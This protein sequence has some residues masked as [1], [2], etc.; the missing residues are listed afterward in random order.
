MKVPSGAALLLTATL[1]FGSITPCAAGAD[2]APT[3]ITIAQ[4]A[5][6]TPC[7]SERSNA[8][9]REVADT[10]IDALNS[11][12]PTTTSSP[13]PSATP[14]SP[15]I[16]TPLRGPGALLATPPPTPIPSV[17]A[18]PLPTPTP[19]VTATAG[20]IF[21]SRQG[22]TTTAQPAPTL[23]PNAIAILADEV[24]GSEHLDQPG[25]AVGHVHIISNDGVITAD[26]AHYDGQRYITLTGHPTLVNPTHDTTL[27]ASRILFDTTTRRAILTDGHGATNRGVEQGLLHY[28][29]QTLTV[30][31]TGEIIG[32]HATLSTCENPRGGYHIAARRLDILPGKH[33]VARGALLY[34]GG[35]AVFFL[36]TLVIPLDRRLTER[37]PVI[38]APEIGYDQADGPYVKARFG[39]GTTNTYYGYYRLEDY[40]RRGLGIGYVAFIGSRDGHRQTHIDFYHFQAHDGTGVTDNLNVTDHETFSKRTTGDFSA[41]YTGDYGP[42]I[43]LPPSETLSGTVTHTTTKSSLTTSFSKT[44]VG[45]EQSTIT[46]AIEDRYALSANVSQALNVSYTDSRNNYN[47]VTTPISSLHLNT[48]TSATTKSVDYQLTVDQTDS[49]IPS[50]YNKVPELVVHPHTGHGVIPID[51]QLTLGMYTEPSDVRSTSRAAINTTFGPALF[52]VFRTS[53]LSATFGVSQYAYG[54]GDLKAQTLQNINLTTPINRHISNIISYQEQNLAGPQSAPF[55][56]LDVLGGAAHTA[57]E[58]LRIANGGVYTL[59][60]STSTAFDHTSQPISYQLSSH[61]SPRSTLILGGSYVPGSGQDFT[62]TNLQLATPFGRNQELEF[63]T[64]IDWQNHGRLEDK[65]VYLRRIIGNCYDIRLSYNQDLKSVNISLDLLAFPSHSANFGFASQQQAVFPQSFVLP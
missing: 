11:V 2:N 58:L 50:G 63:T 45:S 6:D 32:E 49:P 22:R 35:I 21:L 37:H 19:L 55:S 24:L 25:D 31:H 3:P 12:N 46:T 30:Q 17:T 64:N 44:S 18:P 7:I 39:F 62:S 9:N 38:F 14:S 52:K 13:T 47:G 23:A 42:Y 40:S 29:A 15:P 33:L 65:N 34:L 20:P 57:Q 27:E 60:L 48:L 5:L 36:P 8:P 26:R 59:T 4:H 56:T 53:D 41:T 43:S 51:T 28:S 16:T 54:T 61:P 1:L 10:N